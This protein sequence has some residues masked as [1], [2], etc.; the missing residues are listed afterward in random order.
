MRQRHILA[1][2]CLLPLAGLACNLIN[3]ATQAPVM[4][5]ATVVAA[6]TIPVVQVLWPPSGS[7][8]VIRDEIAVRV[9]AADV[10]GVT[11]LE[12][13][14]ANMVLS[15]VPSPE[16]N[17]QPTF[18][19]ILSWTPTR[20]GP[21]DLEV[22]AYRRRVASDPVPL[23]LN[24]RQRSSD[25]IATPLPFGVSAPVSADSNAACQVRVDIDNLRYREGPS[26]NYTINGLLTLGETLSVTG[27]NAAGSWFRIVRDGQSAWVSA[28]TRYT[29][30]L[31]SCA[32]APVVS[33]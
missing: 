2:L 27:K 22:V 24:I 33:P 23:T 30:E 8:F 3:D 26:T 7:E 10:V 12:L 28:D 21:Y 19:A 17:G 20:S 4:P 5:T 29:T 25:V 11:R 15:S 31:T 9:S 14:S 1:L 16:R 32:A 6:N 18:D 13:R